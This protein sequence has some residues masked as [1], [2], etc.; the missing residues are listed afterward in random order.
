METERA[1][2]KNAGLETKAEMYVIVCKVTPFHS[3][4]FDIEID[5]LKDRDGN[6][7]INNNFDFDENNI[8]VLNDGKHH[9]YLDG[10]NTLHIIVSEILKEVYMLISGIPCYHETTHYI[11][12]MNTVRI[13]LKNPSIK[14]S[15]ENQVDILKEKD[16]MD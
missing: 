16:S 1:Q 11:V 5:F 3:C 12:Q 9:L 13:P 7:I 14:Y 6:H 4:V 10:E 8:C 15:I 2:E